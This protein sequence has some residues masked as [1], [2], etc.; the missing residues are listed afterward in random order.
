MSKY[1]QKVIRKTKD[2]TLIDA[3]KIKI[4]SKIYFNLDHD[5]K[6]TIFLASAGRSGSTWVSNI[7]NYQNQY[8]YMFEPFH[9]KYVE[10]CKKFNYRQYLRPEN[11]EEK[12]LNPAKQIVSGRIRDKWIDRFNK[13]LFCKDRLI[14]D[15]R[16]NLLLKWLKDNFPEMKIVLLLRHPLAVVNSRMKLGWGSNIKHF[17]KQ[18]DLI[19]D[20]LDPF[21]KEIKSAESEF[22]K[23]IFSWCIENYVPLKQFNKKEIHVTYYEDFCVNPEET[24]KSLFGFLNIE[25][26]EKIM[27]KIHIPSPEVRAE[28]AILTGDNLID[29]W[30]KSYDK[31][32]VKKAVDLLSIFDLDE[33]YSSNSLPISSKVQEIMK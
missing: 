9:S 33:I 8:R 10:I 12:Y 17:I 19:E 16:A 29:K 15:I 7:I 22:D 20:Y 5:D 31:N 3:V 18:K 32:Q 28:S 1:I 27:E 26:K 23:Q 24:I 21:I 4:H 13:K 25:F 2:G 30:K 14:K 11:N 6:K